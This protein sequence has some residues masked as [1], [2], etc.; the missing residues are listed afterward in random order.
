MP[1][2]F[3]APATAS[4]PSSLIEEMGILCSAELLKDRTR[5][6]TTEQIFPLLPIAQL[7]SEGVLCQELLRL[8]L[9]TF[10]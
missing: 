5:V 1:A 9:N 10:C 6:N 4:L 2:W 3:P 8:N 7:C